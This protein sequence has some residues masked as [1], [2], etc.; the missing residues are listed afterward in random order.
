M[1]V[2]QD[3]LAEMDHPDYRKGERDHRSLKGQR[4]LPWVQHETN[5]EPCHSVK[6]KSYFAGSQT[7]EGCE[8]LRV[9]V[10]ARDGGRPRMA[11]AVRRPEN[12][13]PWSDAVSR[14]SPHT[15]R[16]SSSRTL[17]RG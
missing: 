3:V 11:S 10:S 14:W 1:R 6:V 12:I 2:L 16:P 4:S 15:Q 9:H 7:S 13:A 8:G 17:W 5:A